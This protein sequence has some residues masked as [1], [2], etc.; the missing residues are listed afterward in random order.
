MTYTIFISRELSED[1]LFHQLEAYNCDV[2]SQS[3]ISFSPI[4]F[5]HFPSCDYVFFYSKNAVRFF[6]EQINKEIDNKIKWA[7]IGKSTSDY[8]YHNMNIKADFIGNGKPKET[9]Q[10]FKKVAQG[11]KVLFP[12]AAQS[13]KSIQTLLK[14]DLIVIDLMVYNNEKIKKPFY[15]SFDLLI[16]TSPLNVEAFFENNTYQSQK[17]VVI[18]HTTAQ[19]LEQLKISDYIVASQPFESVLYEKTLEI[20]NIQE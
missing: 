13:K 4:S 3:L 12:R 1:S 6:F 7:C 17:I 8:L 20:L 2:I 16:F 10:E 9:A 18:G 15:Q 5:S 19:A 11:K 14:E